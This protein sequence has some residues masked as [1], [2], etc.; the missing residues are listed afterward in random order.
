MKKCFIV[1]TLLVCISSYGENL[2]QGI[3]CPPVV[4]CQSGS[5][6][7]CN[8]D[9]PINPIFKK[10]IDFS[11]PKLLS[12]PVTFLF[13]YAAS[14]LGGGNAQCVYVNK[15]NNYAAFYLETPSLAANLKIQNQWAT[16][17]GYLCRTSD[18]P[19]SDPRVCPF[20]VLGKSGCTY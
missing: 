1:S 8:S 17:G 10:R 16:S 19:P 7:A 4:V 9:F 2:I 14:S 15:E 3:Y 11:N 13:E 18:S 6:N 5:I 20:C 12:F